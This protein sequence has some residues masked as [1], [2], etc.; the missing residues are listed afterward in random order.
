MSVIDDHWAGFD[1]PQR[2]ALRTTA[3]RIRTLLPG[4]V[5]ALS[6]S[7]P[8]FTISG[9]AVVGIEGFRTH[10]SL[11]PFSGR[12][13]EELAAQLQ[14]RTVTKGGIHFPTQE[15]FPTALLRRLLR[16]K[17][18]LINAGFPRR[19][20]EIREF[21]SDGFLKLEGKQRHGAMHGAWRWYRRDGSLMRSGSFAD[22]GQVGVWTTY[23]RSG[24]V[25]KETDL[26]RA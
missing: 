24:S 13:V 14:G 25:V 1:Q 23:D 8:A 17:I 6:Y 3:D 18:E 19:N 16:R 5:D 4:A 12:I 26:G 11:F 15:P 22:G 9:I 20:G 21:Y 2:E 7:M 10:N